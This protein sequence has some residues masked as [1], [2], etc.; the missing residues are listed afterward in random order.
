MMLKIV[1]DAI[2]LEII[3]TRQQIVYHATWLTILP[4]LIQIIRTK[5]FLLIV[6][7]VTRLIRD[8]R[9]LNICN[10]MLNIF[11]YIV[12]STMGNGINAW[13]VIRIPQ[14]MLSLP[15]QPAIQIPKWMTSTLGLEAIHLIVLPV[16]LAILPGKRMTTLIII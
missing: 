2:H 5:A 12:A 9:L 6:E 16:W 7:N 10:M 1:P 11:Q 15:V 8:G 14:I 13:N 4:P 3:Q